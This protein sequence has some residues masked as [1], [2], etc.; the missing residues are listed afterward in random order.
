M[1]AYVAELWRVASDR[2]IWADTW[3]ALLASLDD[4]VLI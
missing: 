3:S 2:E 1:N 4:G